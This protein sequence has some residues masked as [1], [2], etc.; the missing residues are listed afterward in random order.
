MTSLLLHVHALW[1]QQKGAPSTHI[2]QCATE[3][4]RTEEWSCRTH[5]LEELNVKSSH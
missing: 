4:A 3:A 5:A 2:P 1:A